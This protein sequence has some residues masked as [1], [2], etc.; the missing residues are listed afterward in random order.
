MADGDIHV[1]GT[2]RGRALAG[3]SGNKSAKVR[4]GLLPMIV[5]LAR[6]RTGTPSGQGTV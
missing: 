3:L 1:Y 4:R 2:L 6:N 5:P